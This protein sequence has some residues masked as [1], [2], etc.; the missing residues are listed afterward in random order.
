MDFEVIIHDEYKHIEVEIGDYTIR[1][2]QSIEK[3]GTGVGLSPG[4]LLLASV[5]SC[6]ASTA[7]SYCHQKNLPLPTGMSVHV[8]GD[9]EKILFEIHLLVDFPENRIT[10][11]IRAANTCWV[12]KQWLNPPKFETEVVCKLFI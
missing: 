3:G 4:K 1:T 9:I 2:D 7:Y 10:A 6:T 11:V 8:D 12:K 5:A